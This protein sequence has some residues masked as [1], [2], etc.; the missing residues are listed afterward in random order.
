M[1]AQSTGAIPLGGIITSFMGDEGIAMPIPNS[2]NVGVSNVFLSDE[3]INSPNY[4]RN[5]FAFFYSV[6]F[7][8]EQPASEGYVVVRNGWKKR[9]W[10]SLGCVRSGRGYALVQDVP[11][12]Y[13][14]HFVSGEVAY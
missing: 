10:G 6:K 13:C 8:R 3:I 14:S 1:S 11:H 4:P 2:A 7:L 12:E 9:L 5:T